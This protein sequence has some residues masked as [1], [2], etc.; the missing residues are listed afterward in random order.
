MGQMCSKG[1]SVVSNGP[2]APPAEPTTSNISGKVTLGAGC[3]WGTEKFIKKDFQKKF[4]GSIK[5]AKVGFMSPD[6]NAVKNPSYEAVCS[7]KTGH[8]EVLHL[9]LNNPGKHYEELIRFFF[10]FHD[11]TTKNRQGNDVG[12]QY[13]SYIFTADDEQERIATNVRDELQGFLESG[14]IKC[15]VGKKVM[16]SI[17]PANEFYE[18][19]REHQE[20]LKKNPYGYCNHYIRMKDWP[21]NDE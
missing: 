12:T 13:A 6:E 1:N 9:E 14:R 3:Y 20:Y 18:A 15:F 21:M 2:I 10:Q 5:K 7:G 19:H 4:P 16:T 8:V 17:S 11:P